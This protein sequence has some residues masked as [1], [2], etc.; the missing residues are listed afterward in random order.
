MDTREKSITPQPP[1]AMTDTLH[2]K[3]RQCPNQK[4]YNARR[5]SSISPSEPRASFP[6]TTPNS[7]KAGIPKPIQLETR[8]GGESR[9]LQRCRGMSIF[10]CGAPRLVSSNGS[11]L[12]PV[13]LSFRGFFPRLDFLPAGA[14]TLLI[15]YR[16]SPAISF[17]A[18]LPHP[19]SFTIHLSCFCE[20]LQ[21]SR[22]HA[23][24]H[25]MHCPLIN[26]LN[27]N[28][29]KRLASAAG[30]SCSLRWGPPTYLWWK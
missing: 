2:H 18:H 6:T 4:T 7:K 1:F 5:H 28:K 20:E 3:D 14:A 23:I 13:S 9:G 22:H 8:R 15:Q 17:Q 24:S 10:K 26:N 11:F 21:S 30:M 12:F 19:L 16:L 25:A 27:K 29:I